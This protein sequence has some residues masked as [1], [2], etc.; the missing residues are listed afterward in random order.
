MDRTL[1]RKIVTYV[2]LFRQLSPQ[3][4]ESVIG[5]S[6]LLKVKRGT[7]IIKEGE[8][9]TA[10]YIMVEG[11]ARVFKRLQNNELTQLADLEAPSVFGEM[12]LIDRSPRSASVG[13]LTDTI[14]YQVDLSEFNKLREAYHPAAYKVL[15]E[16][17]PLICARLRQI[18]DRI[19]DFFQNPHEEAEELQVLTPKESL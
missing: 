1:Y 13:T 4:L 18:N 12:A 10:M 17:A 14:L 16:L 9:G 6:R 7:T 5:I 8:Q 15:R 19:G 3:E 11:K 2:P